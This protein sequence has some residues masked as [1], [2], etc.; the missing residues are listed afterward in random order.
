MPNDTTT[1]QLPSGDSG[2]VAIFTD[3]QTPTQ[4]LSAGNTIIDIELPPNG[5]RNIWAVLTQQ[6]QDHTNTTWASMNNVKN[7]VWVLPKAIL[8]A[9]TYTYKSMMNALQTAVVKITHLFYAM[10]CYGTKFFERGLCT[11]LILFAFILQILAQLSRNSP[12]KDLD[13]VDA[14]CMYVHLPQ[15]GLAI[16]HL[17]DR[18]SQH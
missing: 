2:A 4:S 8:V 16:S 14:Q 18:T 6:F 7:H 13:T 3:P 15:E 10:W 11:L 12:Y 1:L 5:T 9:A 17:S